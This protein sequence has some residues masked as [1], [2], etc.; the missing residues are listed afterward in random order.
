MIL[1]KIKQI[2]DKNK[3]EKLLLD[4]KNLQFARKNDIMSFKNYKSYLKNL[5]DLIYEATENTQNG[6]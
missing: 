1:K 6:K 2:K 4:Y 5:I 3:R